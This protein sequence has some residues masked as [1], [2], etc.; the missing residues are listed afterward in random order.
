[1]TLDITR[2]RDLAVSDGGFVFDPVTGQTFTVNDTGLFVLRALKDARAVD[3]IA[4]AVASE[5]DADGSEDIARDVEGFVARLREQ[6]L[7]R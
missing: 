1:M 2:L 3:E 7:V 4:I 5:F 6:G